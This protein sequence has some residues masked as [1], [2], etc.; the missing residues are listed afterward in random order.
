MSYVLFTPP[1]VDVGMVRQDQSAP[2]RAIARIVGPLPTGG[3]L[4]RTSGTWA[5]IRHPRQD[6]ID[7][8]D[9]DTEEEGNPPL[10]YQG[11]HWHWVRK[12]IYDEIVA[13]DLG[14]ISVVTGPGD[15]TFPS[16]STYPG[17]GVH[18]G[19]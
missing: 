3:S 14:D 18:P 2:Q 19:D 5:F 7:A 16:D 12:A 1:T 10:F 9:L 8:V 4:L 17:I 15:G 13:A 6:Q 11:G